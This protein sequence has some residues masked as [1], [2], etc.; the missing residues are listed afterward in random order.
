M[1]IK[2]LFEAGCDGD[3]PRLRRIILSGVDVNGVDASGNTA[4]LM[5]AGK[6]KNFEVVRL[7]VESGAFVDTPDSANWTALMTSSLHG[8][9]DTAVFL[10]SKGADVNYVGGGG[11]TPIIVAAWNNHLDVV[12]LLVEAGAKADVCSEK[13]KHIIDYAFDDMNIS[14]GRLAIA[15]ILVRSGA[16]IDCL[17]DKKPPLYEQLKPLYESVNI[18]RN[19]KVEIEETDPGIGL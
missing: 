5:A 10:L 3:L 15:K 2:D 17:K 16:S 9:V 13:G 7:L 8:G 6:W 1:T 19:M 18:K 4:L 11:C 12:Q 14:E